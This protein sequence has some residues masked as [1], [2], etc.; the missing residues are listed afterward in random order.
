VKVEITNDDD[1]TVLYEIWWP[2][3]LEVPGHGDLIR[4]SGQDYEVHR[5][6]WDLGDRNTSLAPVL[7]LRVATR[8]IPGGEQ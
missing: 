5:R 2:S 6:I 7:R 8:P 3:E 1:G 4:L